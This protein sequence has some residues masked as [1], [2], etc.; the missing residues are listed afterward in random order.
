MNQCLNLKLKLPVA[1]DS[2]DRLAQTRS[3]RVE[4]AGDVR[5]KESHSEFNP[6]FVL[7]GRITFSFSDNDTTLP[8]SDSPPDWSAEQHLPP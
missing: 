7:G 6:D 2:C 4:R 5:C 8:N 3:E 1:Y